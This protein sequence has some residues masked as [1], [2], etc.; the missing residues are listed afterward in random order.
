[1]A[2]ALP[3]ETPK[4][5]RGGRTP[6]P[7]VIVPSDLK[8]G[9]FR[10]ITELTPELMASLCN[11]VQAGN[12]LETALKFAGVASDTMM[13]WVEL[14]H[15]NPNT[16]Y[17]TFVRN[18]NKAM[19]ASEMRDL[20]FIDRAMQDGNWQAA[21]WRLERKYPHRW[22]RNERIAN[23]D[24]MES[25]VINDSGPTSRTRALRKDRLKE[26]SLDELKA[27]HSV[28]TKVHGQKALPEA[29]GGP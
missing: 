3:D 11:V 22:G 15:M 17:G 6:K 7:E 25:Q 28:L 2:L 24:C 29:S 16:I 13:Q 4:K 8:T 26:C 14:G 20:N 12:Y 10:G 19:A 18:M 5:R 21:A 23:P 27:L 1:M 9:F